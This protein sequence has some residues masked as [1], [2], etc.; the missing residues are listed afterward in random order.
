MDYHRLDIVQKW[1][2]LFPSGSSTELASLFTEDGEW[3]D[4]AFGIRVKGRG[5]IK[6]HFN[7]WVRSV[8]DFCMTLERSWEVPEGVV[9]IYHGKGVME[10]DLPTQKA[11]S[12]PFEFQGF[13][14]FQFR[15]SFIQSLDESYTRTYQEFP[16]LNSYSFVHKT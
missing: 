9:A 4:H 13:V 12:K 16:S 7:A 5:A 15:E 11:Y 8:P 14:Y 10:K 3:T 2:S 6:N 1:I